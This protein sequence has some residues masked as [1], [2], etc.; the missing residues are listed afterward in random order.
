MSGGRVNTDLVDL[1]D[2]FDTVREACGITRG[3]VLVRM[4]KGGTL[5]GRVLDSYTGDPIA[6]ATFQTG[7]AQDTLLFGN[8]RWAK[9]TETVLWD[10]VYSPVNGGYTDEC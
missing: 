8:V 9:W 7:I 4:T 10:S 2:I 6:G 3:D 5:K 1:V